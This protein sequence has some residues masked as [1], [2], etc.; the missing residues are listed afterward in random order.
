MKNFIKSILVTVT[1][2]LTLITNLYAGNSGGKSKY[3][4]GFQNGYESWGLS[5]KMDLSEKASVQGIIGVAGALTNFSGK[6]LYKFKSD[7][8]WDFYG[9]GQAGIWMWDGGGYFSDETI[10]GFG[11]GAG[12]EWDWR[13]LSPDLPPIYWNLELGLGFI[14]FDNYNFSSINIGLGV[15]YRF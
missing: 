9:Y 13:V 4:L 15:H 8:Y 1:I 14:N 7:Q 3:Y 11:G 5:G 6:G 10:F 12:I 2:T